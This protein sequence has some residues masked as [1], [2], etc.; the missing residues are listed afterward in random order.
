M[1]RGER[2]LSAEVPSID[3]KGTD[4]GKKDYDEIDELR[5]RKCK[6]YIV[7]ELSP[8]AGESKVNTV[9]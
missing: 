1:K 9:M 7:L 8:I 4:T 5:I 2:N 6:A 3:W